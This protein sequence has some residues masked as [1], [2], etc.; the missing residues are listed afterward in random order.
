MW[1]HVIGKIVIFTKY[2][3][4]IFQVLEGPWDLNPGSYIESI[5]TPQ[6]GSPFSLFSGGA[7]FT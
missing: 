4:R 2:V 5:K 7:Q 6:S 3:F 1:F